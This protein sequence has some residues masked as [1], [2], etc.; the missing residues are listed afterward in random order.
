ME[1]SFSLLDKSNLNPAMSNISVPAYWLYGE[2]RD[3]RFPDAL[4]IE[5]IASRSSLHNWRIQPH[6]HHDLFQFFVLVAGGGKARIDGQD[7]ELSPGTA[8]V[9]PPLVIHEFFFEPGTNGFVASVADLSLK[10]LLTREAGIAAALARPMVLVHGQDEAE[11]GELVT[12]MQTALE[13]FGQNRPGREGALSAYAD[14]IA[15]W[16]WRAARKHTAMIERLKD[17]RALLVR[18]FIES[19]EVDF[20]THQPLA[21]Y[22]RSL[23]VSVPHLTRTCRQVLGVP[24]IRVIHDRLMLEARRYLVYTSMTISQ[25]AFGLGFSDPA[26]FSRFFTARA[27]VAPSDYRAS[28]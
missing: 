14:L 26:Y 22:A 10:H 16:F 8:I 20:R 3:G 28:G 6:R 27:A 11:L 1:H 18:R 21:A 17:A 12:I 7:H 25:I 4:H 23:G 24:A 15:I 2:R 5:M 19:V 13:E 9:M